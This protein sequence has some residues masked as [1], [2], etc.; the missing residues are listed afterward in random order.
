MS[1]LCYPKVYGGSR[2]LKGFAKMDVK[3]EGHK[4]SLNA[5]PAD[6]ENINFEQFYSIFNENIKSAK[7]TIFSANFLSFL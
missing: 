6:N 1:P 2:D 4:L 3:Q 7:S 5:S